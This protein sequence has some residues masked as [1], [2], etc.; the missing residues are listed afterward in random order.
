[1][2]NIIKASAGSGKTFTLAKEY[3]TL[4]LG[5]TD[6]NGKWVL[7]D[8][9]RT[10]N[11]HK[12][13]LAITFT[14]KATE[15]MKSRI[16]AELLMLAD[17]PADS[18]YIA[19]L[20]AKYRA[21]EQQISDTARRALVD[22]LFNYSDFN[23]S[24]IDSF[25]QVILRMF[26]RD[27]ELVDDFNVEM[28]DDYVISVG[29]HNLINSLRAGEGT[30]NGIRQLHSWL[31]KSIQNKID[32]KQ[33]WNVFNIDAGTQNS[34]S[35]KLS[36]KAIA[37]ILKTEG[38]KLR[39]KEII[40]YLSDF[41][42]IKAFQGELS[43][44]IS[45][46]ENQLRDSASQFNA[47]VGKINGF[48]ASRNLSDRD[49]ESF[50]FAIRRIE[51]GDFNLDKFLRRPDISGEIKKT[52]KISEAVRRDAE[53]KLRP[54]FDAV[55]RDLRKLKALKS[56]R[57]NIYA[58]GLLGNI[59]KNV[60]QFRAEN[61]II[62]LSDTNDLLKRIITE[63]DAP[64]IY[65]RIGMML[66]NYLIDEFQDT[67][68]MQWENLHPLLSESLSHN[69]AN[70]IIGDEKQ[71]IYRFR[72]AEPELLQKE[73]NSQL[74]KF[75]NSSSLDTNYRSSEVVVKFN[76]AFFSILSQK[77]TDMQFQTVEDTYQNI[78]QKVA[79][80]KVGSGGY[81]RIEQFKK[82]DDGLSNAQSIKAQMLDRTIDII[83]DIIARGYRQRDILVLVD[84]NDLGTEV[85]E[86]LKVMR[87][88]RK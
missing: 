53:D 69:N 7:N 3:I 41:S 27:V 45:D 83:H 23:I 13:I 64:F 42:K 88:C 58:L 72:N 12:R 36:L 62:L 2:L 22:L 87:T 8:P 82:I 81:V 54:I 49:G 44:K 70:L 17:K 76:N 63:D 73:V 39:K 40:D 46:F 21:S 43:H 67:S 19:D 28:E 86:S 11:A 31:L 35:E 77:L 15:E 65:E 68:R 18:N 56:V 5:H 85:I 25:F 20:K 75:V 4:L 60:E 61:E 14:N 16:V 84:K 38:F 47:A 30:D 26:A 55:Q 51:Q 74:G 9:K 32:E 66:S 48:D 79:P 6:N 57:N 24:T 10:S 59:S 37:N 34:Y 80:T 50:L 71:S 1:M 33:G 29:I 78:V 52:P